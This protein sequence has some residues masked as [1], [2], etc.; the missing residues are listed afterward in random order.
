MEWSTVALVLIT[1]IYATLTWL[2][3]RKTDSALEQTDDIIKLNQASLK[4]T[5][6]IIKQNQ[7]S[8]EQNKKIIRQN[9][10]SH[11]QTDRMI[12]QGIVEKNILYIEKRLERLYYPLQ[13]ALK[14]DEVYV[15]L[16][17]EE[18]MLEEY[19]GHSDNGEVPRSWLVNEN[20][21]RYSIDDVIPYLYLA[22]DKLRIP[23]DE[24]LG[25][26]RE[27]NP[28]ES[29]TPEGR[30][31]LEYLEKTVISDINIIE[32]KLGKLRESY[33]EIEDDE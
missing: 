25:R 19:Y 10:H 33:L 28:Y 9:G 22:S 24:F 8:L 23:L 29:D 31:E 30:Q 26:I 2:I 4:K 15:P 11:A 16:H 21:R 1:A 27:F 12:R 18:L 14:S 32:Q 17:Y 3:V 7:D 6:A 5:D 20:T 13:D